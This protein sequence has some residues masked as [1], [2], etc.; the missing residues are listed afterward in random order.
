M[1]TR[2]RFQLNPTCFREKLRLKKSNGA[3]RL[4][5][6]WFNDNQL[7]DLHFKEHCFT[8]LKGSL[9]KRLDRA[10]CNDQWNVSFIK[11]SVLHLPKIHFDHCPILF[12]FGLN[13]KK[14][15]VVRSFHFLP[16]WLT[17][18]TFQSLVAKKWRNSEGYIQGAHDFVDKVFV[19]NKE[20]F[21]NNFKRKRRLLARLNGI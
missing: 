9:F 6:K 19:W 11:A 13:S 10:I 17:D 20:N 3:C 7:M 16:A 12:R 4:F 18:Q 15:N 2:W 21:R 5:N 8:W 1:A 14:M